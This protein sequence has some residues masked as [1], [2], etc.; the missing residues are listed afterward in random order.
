MPL[1]SL[2]D[3][4]TTGW[5]VLL[6]PPSR[7]EGSADCPCEYISWVLVSGPWPPDP[8]CNLFYLGVGLFS[9]GQVTH[10][11]LFPFE[12]III[13]CLQSSLIVLKY[14]GRCF[15]RQVHSCLGNASC[16]ALLASLGYQHY[17]KISCRLK[18]FWQ[19]N[20]EGF[21]LTDSFTT[22]SEVWLSGCRAYV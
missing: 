20:L 18:F 7:P 15:W 12:E 13:N 3:S 9:A 19:C 22:V 6:L 17:Y 14:C 5:N 11:S 8:F 21:Y 16:K 1:S 2:L 10:L 4:Q